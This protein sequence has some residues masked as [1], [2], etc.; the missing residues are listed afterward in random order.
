MFQRIHINAHDMRVRVGV[1]VCEY[2]CVWVCVRVILIC[3][4]F[5][6]LIIFRRLFYYLLH[7]VLAHFQSLSLT[8]PLPNK[9]NN[10]NCKLQNRD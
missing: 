3:A 2:V 9:N 8:P 4:A 6:C 10:N 5:L 1:R 7:Q